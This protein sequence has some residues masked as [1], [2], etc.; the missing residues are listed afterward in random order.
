MTK[1][2]SQLKEDWNLLANY[3]EGLGRSDKLTY[4]SK[5]I[6]RN[7]FL[8]GSISKELEIAEGRKMFGN[9]KKS[10]QRTH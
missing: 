8:F 4:A 3:F 9:E 7:A 10:D 6:I 5:T 2:V 1:K